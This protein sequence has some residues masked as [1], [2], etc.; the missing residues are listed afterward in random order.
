MQILQNLSLY[1][2]SI[3]NGSTQK[4][5]SKVSSGTSSY[6]SAGQTPISGEPG[7]ETMGLAVF[8]K[9][10]LVGEL[11]GFES[12]CHCRRPKLN[13]IDYPTCHIDKNL[14]VSF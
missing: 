10:K 13:S 14:L 3:N 11:N 6:Y 8:N 9:D 1:F 5:S 4:T 12:I 2:G 7:V